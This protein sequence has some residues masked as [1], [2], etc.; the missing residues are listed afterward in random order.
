MGRRMISICSQY[1]LNNSSLYKEILIFKYSD[2]LTIS[3]EKE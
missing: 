1:R 2:A 3:I